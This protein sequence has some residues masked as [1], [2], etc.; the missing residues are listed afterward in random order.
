DREFVL[1]GQLLDL[2]IETYNTGYDY[3]LSK[4]IFD[5]MSE[6]FDLFYKVDMDMTIDTVR[7]I[8]GDLRNRTYKKE[9]YFDFINGEYVLKEK[10]SKHYYE[11]PF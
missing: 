10:F 4:T 8:G 1:K 6:G 7:K 9:T 3:A 11:A 2:D 5:I